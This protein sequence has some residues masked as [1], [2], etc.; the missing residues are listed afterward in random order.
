MGQNRDKTP[1]GYGY[2]RDPP[3]QVGPQGTGNDTG[4]EI[5][6]VLVVSHG[7][8]RQGGTVSYRGLSFRLTQRNKGFGTIWGDRVP[9]LFPSP[10]IKRFVQNYTDNPCVRD[11]GRTIQD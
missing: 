3:G 6:D 11:L 1:L 2:T 5:V 4:Q 10:L 8:D 9:Y 7:R